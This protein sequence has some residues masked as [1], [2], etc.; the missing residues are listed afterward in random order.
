MTKKELEAARDIKKILDREEEALANIKNTG[1][2][3]SSLRKAGH[4][5]AKAWASWERIAEKE[6]Q[7]KKLCRDLD[8][9]QELIRRNL[10]KAGLD[11]HEMEIMKLLYVECMEWSDIALCTN[12]SIRQA[13]RIRDRAMKKVV[14]DG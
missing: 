7:I 5:R 12:Y 6:E 13:Q 8:L 1:G 3:G 9:E 14:E 10:K 2:I 11:H 4:G